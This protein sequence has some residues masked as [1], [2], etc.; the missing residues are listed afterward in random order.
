M[1]NDKPL[2]HVDVDSLTYLTP[3]QKKNLQSWIDLQEVLNAGEFDE[4]MDAF[5]HP[6]M[7]YGNPSRPD[8]GSYRE[9]KESPRQLYRVFPPS[10]YR[11]V[12]AVG[13]GDDEIWV[14]CEHMGEHVGGRYM[15]VEPTGNPIKV[16]WFS[17]VTFKDGLIYRIFSIA[18]VLTMLIQV[19]VVEPSALPVDP[20][21]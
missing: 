8:L 13:K 1:E 16:E 15:G 19:G 10:R 4:K 14:Y 6:D 17:V 20:Y 5:F 21:K 2:P 3:R 11:V 7:T 12:D 18:D 9:W